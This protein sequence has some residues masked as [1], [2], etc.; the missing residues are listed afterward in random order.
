MQQ[1]ISDTFIVYES[2]YKNYKI[3]KQ[4]YLKIEIHNKTKDKIRAFIT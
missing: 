2:S 1:L 3:T 4:L